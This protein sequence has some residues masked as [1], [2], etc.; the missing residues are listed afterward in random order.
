VNQFIIIGGNIGTKKRDKTQPTTHP[1]GR[2]LDQFV[3]LERLGRRRQVCELRQ[4]E[5]RRE[6]LQIQNKNNHI[7]TNDIQT[8]DNL[9]FMISSNLPKFAQL[10]LARTKGYTAETK[11]VPRKTKWSKPLALKNGSTKTPPVK[12]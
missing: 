5:R 3:A 8:N 12:G 1:N 7:Q 10:V 2:K 11:V 6:C 9:M 4:I